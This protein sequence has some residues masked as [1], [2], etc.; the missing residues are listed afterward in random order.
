MSL[1]KA[2]MRRTI[3]YPYIG[4][5][6]G[7]RI[8]INQR[9]AWRPNTYRSAPSRTLEYLLIGGESDDRTRIER[10]LC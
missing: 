10:R 8:L 1:P 9:R 7:D 3:E 2:A 5:E 4:D 6:S